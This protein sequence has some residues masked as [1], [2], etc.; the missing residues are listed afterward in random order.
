MPGPV[1]VWGGRQDGQ[2]GGEILPAHIYSN[3]G[4]R[5]CGLLPGLVL[6]RF[7]APPLQP[8]LVGPYHSMGCVVPHP[9]AARGNQSYP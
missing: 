2:T 3:E 1:L 4:K 7:V 6:F 8:G 5:R 9:F